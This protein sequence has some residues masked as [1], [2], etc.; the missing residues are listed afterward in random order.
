MPGDSCTVIEIRLLLLKIFNGGRNK[1]IIK[2]V[3]INSNV[4]ECSTF[5]QSAN[6]V[7]VSL[8]W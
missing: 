4:F 8:R 5:S 1:K 2:S 6:D 3:C 7:L